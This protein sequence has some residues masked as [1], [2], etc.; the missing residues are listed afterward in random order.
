MMHAIDGPT[1]PI[2]RRN[3]RG[4][5]ITSWPERARGIQKIQV[6]KYVRTKKIQMFLFFVCAVVGMVMF[7]S[8]VKYISALSYKDSLVKPMLKG[9]PKAPDGLTLFH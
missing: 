9:I 2:S 3:I 4:P 6:K 1:P 8:P 7:S 5:A